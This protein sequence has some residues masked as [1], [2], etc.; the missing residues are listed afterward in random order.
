MV[1]LVLLDVAMVL[2]GGCYGVARRLLWCLLGGCNG[3]VGVSI[4]LLWIYGV[5]RWL[6]VVARWLLWCCMCCKVIAM[7]LLGGCYGVARCCYGVCLEVAI[8]LQG[9]AMV[10]LGAFYGVAMC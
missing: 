9:V 7:M 1:A 3:F 4:V 10:L 2:L 8:V 5:A 6:L